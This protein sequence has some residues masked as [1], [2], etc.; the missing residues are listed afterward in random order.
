MVFVVPSSILQTIAAELARN[1]DGNESRDFFGKEKDAREEVEGE[2]AEMEGK[3]GVAD[4]E[5]REEE[6]VAEGP[7]YSPHTSSEEATIFDSTQVRTGTTALFKM[8]RT[9]SMPRRVGIVLTWYI[10]NVCSF[11]THCEVPLE[12]IPSSAPFFMSHIPHP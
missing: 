4:E 5:R 12:M 7:E 3:K 9:V 1:G 6:G 10:M 2:N 8:R 11:I